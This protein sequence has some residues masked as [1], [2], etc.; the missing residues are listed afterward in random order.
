MSNVYDIQESPLRQDIHRLTRRVHRLALHT[1]TIRH[2]RTPYPYGL[3]LR[4]LCSFADRVSPIVVSD[5][6]FLLTAITSATNHAGA[7]CGSFT[8]D[9]VE[10]L[11]NSPEKSNW[12][13]FPHALRNA[14]SGLALGREVSRHGGVGA[15]TSAYRR[16]TIRDPCQ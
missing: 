10:W 9:G 11:S 7:K 14:A 4:I 3:P 6:L 12:N 15:E 2:W 16:L 1:L 5:F 8:G 13:Q